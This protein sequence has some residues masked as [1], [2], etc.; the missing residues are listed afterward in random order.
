[1]PSSPTTHPPPLSE[2]QQQQQQQEEEE[3]QQQEEKATT[4]SP[5]TIPPTTTL[6]QRSGLGV[7]P[8]VTANATTKASMGTGGVLPRRAMAVLLRMVARTS[9]L[10]HNWLPSARPATR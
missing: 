6:I 5:T 4:V 1:M 3:E 8:P 9:C 2:Q 10:P 7:S